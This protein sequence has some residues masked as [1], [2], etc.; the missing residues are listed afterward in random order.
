[1]LV[2][3]SVVVGRL[4]GAG[5]AG[6]NVGPAEEYLEASVSVPD[7]VAKHMARLSATGELMAARH[8][9]GGMIRFLRTGHPL[10][11]ELKGRSGGIMHVGS[12]RCWTQERTPEQKS[13]DMLLV[14]LDPARLR[15]GSLDQMRKAGENGVYIVGFGPREAP[16]IADHVALCDEFFDNGFGSDDRVAGLSAGGRAGRLGVVID[17]LHAWALTAEH[18]AALTRE[19]KMPIMAKSF[20]WEDGREWW[21]HYYKKGEAFHGDIEVPPVK[22]G[23]LGSAYLERLRGL[24]AGLGERETADIRRAAELIVDQVE[25]GKKV[26]VSYVGHM[27]MH[28]VGQGADEV[29]VK[30]FY[31]WYGGKPTIAKFRNYAAP[32][33]VTFR[34]GYAGLHENLSRLFVETDQRLILTSGENIREKWQPPEALRARVVVDIDMGWRMGDACVEL[35]GYPFKLFPPSGITQ[36]AVY[37]AVSTGVL[38]RLGKTVE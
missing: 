23:K 24:L 14:G 30:P 2:L 27:P 1:M 3:L 20:T 8:L 13:K 5:A 34:L 38:E 4:T 15:Q 29:W 11:S 33:D 6:E 9:E 32:D 28:Y 10:P 7:R 25:G 36:Y 19:G 18:V 22:K 31:M 37:Q 16:Q 26:A 35:P 12:G 21:G 17:V